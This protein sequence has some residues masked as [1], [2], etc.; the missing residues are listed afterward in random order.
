MAGAIWTC[1]AISNPVIS[2]HWPGNELSP[3]VSVIIIIIVVAILVVIV[4]AI[5]IVIV[6]NMRFIWLATL[7]CSKI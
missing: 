7:A 1:V 3:V 5:V 2:E 4:I 6:R